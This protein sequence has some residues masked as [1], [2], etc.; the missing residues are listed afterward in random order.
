M[1]QTMK[2]QDNNLPSISNKFIP[3]FTLIELM[4][5]IAIIAILAAVAYPSYQQH[6]Q[7]TRRSDALD[8]LQF[9]AHMQE[10]FLTL[11]NTYATTA[12]ALGISATSKKGYYSLSTAA[13]TTTTFTLTV[14]PSAGST[15]LKDTNCQQF[16]FSSQGLR[17]ANDASDGSGTVTTAVCWPQ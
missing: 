4:I 13:P 14:T 9:A 8:H 3:G 5:V 1:D 10:R 16:T 7:K 17:T 2:P 11:N 15:Q 6:L 12:V